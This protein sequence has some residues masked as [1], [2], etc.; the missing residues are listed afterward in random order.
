MRTMLKSKIHRARVT[1]VNLDYE[2]SITIDRTLLETAD[3]LPF[4]RVEVLNIN[5]GA[6]FST[7]AI[8]GEVRSGV[9]GINGAAARLVA[10][11]DIVIILSYCQIPDNEAM[12]MTPTMVYVDN[13]NRILEPSTLRASLG[14]EVI[15]SGEGLE[16]KGVTKCGL[17]SR[18]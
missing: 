3:I 2:G 10:K 16:D 12:T 1:E 7:Y 9:I 14:W 13:K 4:E 18:R 11:G 6:R 5:N 15:L 17:Q 8:E